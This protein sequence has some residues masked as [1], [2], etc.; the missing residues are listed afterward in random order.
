[1]KAISAALIAGLIGCAAVQPATAAQA[2]KA[3]EKV[4][5]SFCSQQDCV[6]G[7]IPMVN[8]IAVNG[9]LYGTTTSGGTG[10]Y[11]EGG[12]A[13]ALDPNTGAEKVLYSFCQQ[14]GCADGSVPR[15]SLIDVNGK[16]Y[17][18]TYGGGSGC[19]SAGCGTV[20]SIDPKTGVET[21]LY[22]FS[23]EPDCTNGARPI[24]SV[25]DTKGMLYGT[26]ESGGAY[27]DFGT[28]FALDPK[29]GVEKVVHSFGSGTDGINPAAGLIDVK[30]KFYGTTPA[31]GTYGHGTVFAFDAK[32]GGETVLHSFGIG[33]DGSIPAGS[34]IDLNGTL[35]GTTTDGGTS[36]SCAEGCG[37]VFSLDP[38]TGAEEVVY[39]FCSLQNC[40]DGWIPGS[41]LLAVKGNLYG[42]TDFGGNAGCESDLGCGTMFA[43][44]PKT[45]KASVFYSFCS[46]QICT[47]GANSY[48]SLIAVKDKLYGTTSVGGANNDGTVF[49]L[50][51]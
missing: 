18:T 50:T 1:M 3:R 10:D 6:D 5:Y 49:V 32:T 14:Q 20:F 38:G 34:L 48:A 24:A 36:T 21:V 42:T 16:L 19:S 40:A 12:V 29:N 51:P 47:D 30:G 45:D 44:D 25:I 43:V 8:V 22:P 4:L 28:V 11:N 37:T 17:S 7:Q 39:S 15:A 35:Y 13:F 23:C 26:T 33:P 9:I 46:E 41:S 27:G 2:G 31:G